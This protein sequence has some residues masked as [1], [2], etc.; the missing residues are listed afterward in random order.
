[1]DTRHAVVGV[2]ALAGL[3]MAFVIG[4]APVSVPTAQ[5]TPA[6]ELG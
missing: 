1:M 6:E 2:V 4:R 3:L 5:Q